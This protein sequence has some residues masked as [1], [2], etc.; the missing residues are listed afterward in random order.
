MYTSWPSKS[1]VVDNSPTVSISRGVL[2]SIDFFDSFIFLCQTSKSNQFLGSLEDKNNMAKLVGGVVVSIAVVTVV[3]LVLIGGVLL[4]GDDAAVVV[5]ILMISGR[6]FNVA[7][8]I[9]PA[10]HAAT[11]IKNHT[12][13]L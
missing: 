1:T 4:I 11:N 13:I 10:M 3:A 5:L 9:M 2:L 12:T 7:I 8:V 6:L